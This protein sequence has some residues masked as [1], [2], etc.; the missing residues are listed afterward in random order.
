MARGC[1]G[2]RVRD[3]ARIIEDRDSVIAE[4]RAVVDRYDDAMQALRTSHGELQQAIRE[5][6]AARR[7]R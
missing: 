2:N 1:G 4:L 7:D 5:I 3:L 6:S